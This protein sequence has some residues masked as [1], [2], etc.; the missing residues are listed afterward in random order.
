[1]KKIF[2]FFIA[3]ALTHLVYSQSNTFPTSGRVG[4]GTI[5]PDSSAIL[6]LRSSDQGLLMP[7]MTMSQRD[8]IGLPA[9]GL[10]I[11]QTDAKPGFYFFSDSTWKGIAVKGIFTIGDTL[12]LSGGKNL[13]DSNTFVGAT[14]N[15][16]NTGTGNTFVGSSAGKSNADGEGCTFVG[17][18]AGQRNGAGIS[19][20]FVGNSA[21]LSTTV[22]GRNSFYGGNAGFFN[23]TG[24]KNCFYGCAAGMNNTTGFTNSFFGYKSGLHN[25]TADL[26]SFFGNESGNTNTTGTQNTFLGARAGDINSTGSFNVF[27][28]YLA[29]G[30]N[31]I[32]SNNT[33]LGIKSGLNISTG[34]NNTFLG[35]Y[36]G[37][38][39]GNINNSIAIGINFNVSQS[40]I[41]QLGGPVITKMGVGKNPDAGDILDFQVTTA[42]LTTGG[43]WTNASDKKLKDHFEDVDKRDILDKINQL[44]I[45]RWHYRADDKSITHIGPFAQDFYKLFGVGDDTTISTIDPA[46]VALL[47]VQELS[48]QNAEKDAAISQMQSAIDQLKTMVYE[49][50]QSFSECCQNYN[51]N[52]MEKT[53]NDLPRLEPNI[54]NPFSKNTVIKFYLPAT[55]KNASIVVSSLVGLEIKTFMLSNSGNGQITFNT[56]NLTAGEY[57]YDLVIDG[58]KVDSKKMTLTK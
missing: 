44:N 53:S 26:N 58:R 2:T 4:I 16:N 22:G 9:T 20:T 48:K 17:A 18:A 8:S 23:T 32:A 49:M 37:A 50:Q 31:T 55:I 46:A 29:G 33:F 6:E 34:G 51:I 3:L 13:A 15:V 24:A 57:I 27:A 21:G 52:N 39:T 40:H 38:T 11:Y 41:I 36:V 25:T 19:N 45:Q 1:M 43:V 28:G 47:A 54:P 14:L 5:T 30:T 10:L 12:F 42:K 7:R 35:A 56:E